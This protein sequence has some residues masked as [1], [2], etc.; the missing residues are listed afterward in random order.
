MTSIERRK[1]FA[2][3]VWETIGLLTA[4]SLG[5]QI[6]RNL[7]PLILEIAIIGPV[8]T[9]AAV[10]VWLLVL[11]RLKKTPGF[12]SKGV[13]KIDGW[14]VKGV[15]AAISTTFAFTLWLMV[16]QTGNSSYPLAGAATIIVFFL[17]VSVLAVNAINARLTEDGNNSSPTGSKKTRWPRRL[18]FGV[19]IG[20]PIILI[21]I[22]SIIYS[23]LHQTTPVDLWTL[24]AF[25]VVP[26][27]LIYIGYYIYRGDTA[28]PATVSAV[29]LASRLGF[30]RTTRGHVGLVI[31]LIGISILG[32]GTPIL[33]NFVTSSSATS[34]FTSRT[35]VAMWLPLNVSNQSLTVEFQ[36]S[37]T[38]VHLLFFPNTLP[39]SAHVKDPGIL[40]V[41]L[42]FRILQPV[43]WS[44]GNWSFSTVNGP[45]I[46]GRKGDGSN[47]SLTYHTAGQY[48]YD[49][50]VCESWFRTESMGVSDLAG[51]SILIPHNPILGTSPIRFWNG[52]VLDSKNITVT[53]QVAIPGDARSLQFIPEF[54]ALQSSGNT[55]NAWMV[56]S[57]DNPKSGIVI[58]YVSSRDFT[59]FQTSLLAAG[60]LIGAGIGILVDAY[61]KYD[62][63]NSERSS[64]GSS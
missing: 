63:V 39:T 36:T 49:C 50:N 18:D 6:V 28:T 35:F 16:L 32:L 10:L 64:N 52:T 12:F 24:L 23:Y 20:L 43:F 9:M 11:K 19:L 4:S 51:T 26:L 21:G 56:A 45:D 13:M 33:S 58:G 41:L 29:P 46:F 1:L 31:I 3:S 15:L 54:T 5:E 59:L 60:V 37:N 53:V 27:L 17:L 62:D 25:Y 2:L 61:V 14:F 44:R 55:P 57:W 22:A 8:T 48:M 34:E 42:P 40:R 47:V 30:I 7:N 38:L